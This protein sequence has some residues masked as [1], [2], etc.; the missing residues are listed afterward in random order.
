MQISELQAG[1][2]KVELTGEIAEVGEPRTFNKFGKEGRVA[3]AVL[4]DDSGQIKLTL[5]NEQVDQVKQG[6]TV[7]IRNGYVSEWQGEL[8]LSTGKFGTLETG[9]SPE[10][11]KDA[12]EENIGQ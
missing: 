1:K 3:N 8:Q 5:W 10:A 12:Q 7:T 11:P 9:G 2:G 6:D 4:K